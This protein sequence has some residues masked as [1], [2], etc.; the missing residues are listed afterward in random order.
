MRNSDLLTVLSPEKS[1][2]PLWIGTGKHLVVD[3][4]AAADPFLIGG[5][6]TLSAY[7]GGLQIA[8]R[9]ELHI[10]YYKSRRLARHFSLT[11][12]VNNDI[13]NSTL[14]KLVRLEES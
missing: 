12:Q 4:V 1:S 9:Q 8:V 3:I 13:I 10:V 2:S 11:N 7:P 14:I 5:R 6:L